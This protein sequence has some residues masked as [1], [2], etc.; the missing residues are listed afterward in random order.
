MKAPRLLSFALSALL[1]SGLAL[2]SP[3]EP[4]AVGTYN[5]RTSSADGNSTNAWKYRKADLAVFVRKLD[6]DVVGFQETK[7][8]QMTFLQKQLPL[9]TMAGHFQKDGKQRMEGNP[10]FFRK[11]RFDL[12][13]EGV[14][15]LSETPEVPG[16]KS[17]DT[18]Y[19]RSC[20]WAILKDKASGATLCFANVHTD[21]I[22]ALAREKG[23][24][25]LLG[26]LEE[27][28]PEG[29]SVVLVGDHNCRENAKPAQL[30]A[31][32]LR[33]A[34]YA[35]KTPPQ[36][37]WRSFTG[38][39]WVEKETPAVDALKV[40]IS[41]RNARKGTP[42]GDRIEDGVPVFRKY[43]SRIDY[44]YVSEGVEVLSYETHADTRP[45]AKLYPSDHFPVTA[46]IEPRP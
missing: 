7:S 43:G 41:V 4:L 16:S 21:H 2:P 26:R 45:A 8:N 28:A 40:D 33:D 14:F 37:P 46:K 27:I 5:I 22:S 9:Y 44:I 30:A 1:L 24:E 29:A 17:W 35:S 3:A 32:K 39:R 31:A 34:L 13:R 18:A 20:T 6:L 19:S 38:W 42:E 12:L 36:G 15:W 10:I 25:L 11:S 23:M